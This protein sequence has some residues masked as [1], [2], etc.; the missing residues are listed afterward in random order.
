MFKRFY[1]NIFP[2][3]FSP[4][5]LIIEDDDFSETLLIYNLPD[6]KDL[7][8]YCFQEIVKI[9]EKRN[10]D[11]A[12]NIAYLV[13]YQSKNFNDSKSC[14]ETEEYK[15]YSNDVEKYLLLI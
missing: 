10:L 15:K 6:Y 5:K 1:L 12:L 13:V 9:Y 2:H 14:K 11:I 7:Q 8:K 4:H 3:D